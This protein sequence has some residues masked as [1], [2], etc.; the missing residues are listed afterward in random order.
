MSPCPFLLVLDFT[1]QYWERDF[2]FQ[3]KSPK[4]LSDISLGCITGDK[5]ILAGKL[6]LRSARSAAAKKSTKSFFQ[7]LLG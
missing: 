4:N 7:S 3:A 5:L 2:T 1:L 6:A